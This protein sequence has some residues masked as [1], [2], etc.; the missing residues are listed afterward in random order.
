[1]RSVL[2][3]SLP[4]TLWLAA[5]SGVYG[6]HGLLCSG[7]WSDIA[8][9]P[10]GRVL[11]AL[12]VLAAIAMQAALLIGLRAPRWRDPDPA[13][14]RASLVLATAALVGTIWTLAP[15]IVLPSACTAPDAPATAEAGRPAPPAAID[16]SHRA[17]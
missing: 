16:P 17:A 9:A 14:R 3:L 2:R 12:V 7:R 13:L 11:L 4:L 8:G 5:F 15:P 6:L 1:M 10:A